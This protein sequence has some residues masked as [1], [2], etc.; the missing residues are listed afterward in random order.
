M[1]RRRVVEDS[2]ESERDERR[3]GHGKSPLKTPAVSLSRPPSLSAA[4]H[5]S[6]KPICDK[7]RKQTVSD[8]GGDDEWDGDEMRRVMG[9]ETPSRRSRWRSR[10]MSRTICDDETSDSNEVGRKVTAQRARNT[11]HE[12]PPTPT[13]HCDTTV[14]I[15]SDDEKS[16]R[17]TPPSS[18]RSSRLA[19]GPSQDKL[20]LRKKLSDL[21]KLR[22]RTQKSMGMLRDSSSEG[23]SDDSDIK[24]MATKH[25]RDRKKWIEGRSTRLQQCE[26]SSDESDTRIVTRFGDN[27]PQDNT[28]HSDIDDMSNFIVDDEDLSEIQGTSKKK[29]G[30]HGHSSADEGGIKRHRR[31]MSMGSLNGTARKR[32]FVVEEEDSCSPGNEERGLDKYHDL[33]DSED[34]VAVD[35]RRQRKKVRVQHYSGPVLGDSFVSDT[36]SSRSLKKKNKNKARGRRRRVVVDEDDM[37]EAE[38]DMNSSNHDDETST[39]DR[40]SEKEVDNLSLYRQLDMERQ[41]HEDENIEDNPMAVFRKTQSIAEAMYDYI[42]LMLFIL[43]SEDYRVKFDDYTDGRYHASE[44]TPFEKESFQAHRRSSRTV[45]NLICTSRESLCGSSA[46]RGDFYQQLS[47]RPFFT[48]QFHGAGSS[49]IQAAERCDACGR[50]NSVYGGYKLCLCGPEYNAGGL[51]NSSRWVD[52]VPAQFYQVLKPY[53]SHRVDAVRTVRSSE[54]TPGRRQQAAATAAL[55]SNTKRLMHLHGCSIRITEEENGPKSRAL[56]SPTVALSSALQSRVKISGGS[57][58]SPSNKDSPKDL[59]AGTYSPND[60]LSLPW[61]QRKWGKDLR[62]DP[63]STWVVNSH[64]RRR[65]QI[66]H[67]LLHYKFRLMIKIRERIRKKALSMG[68]ISTDVVRKDRNCIE[69]VLGGSFVENELHRLETLLREAGA[70]FGGKEQKTQFSIW[71]DDESDKGDD[72][73][74]RKKK[75]SPKSR[76]PQRSHEKG[77]EKP[78]PTLDGWLI[79]RTPGSKTNT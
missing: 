10:R 53:V 28:D 25:L 14:V 63:Q 66:Y 47:T 52:M 56:P 44:C 22:D 7:E 17:S 35:R 59:T 46:W 74:K 41:I 69:E 3:R 13:P 26:Q 43:I 72:S 5:T 9:G 33:G 45:E 24:A 67:T 55:E 23:E 36:A 21:R 64:C 65:T 37:S 50:V 15:L 40:E 57:S 62:D 29:R 49:H 1:Y 71:S 19:K 32:K 61:W 68:T 20:K 76:T 4:S 27:C 2:S 8:E 79:S 54:R 34:S 60:E 51:W 70:S 78:R 77:K 16:I 48:V 58:D 31:S 12:R 38:S 6:M 39:S 11:K 75:S 30:K 42:E 73:S 18:R